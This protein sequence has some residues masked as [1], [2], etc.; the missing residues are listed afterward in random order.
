VYI[1]NIEREKKP[2]SMNL[3]AAE[4]INQKKLKTHQERKLRLDKDKRDR[5]GNVN[6]DGLKTIRS[7]GKRN[8]TIVIDDQEFDLR[9]I[10]NASDLTTED[11][12]AE[13]ED[14]YD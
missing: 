7:N 1:D 5:T 8:Q 10:R 12:L 2:M 14:W 4:E 6:T 9:R 13:M 3:S 11:E